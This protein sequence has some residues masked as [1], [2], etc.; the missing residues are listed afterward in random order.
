MCLVLAWIIQ[1]T[2][3][4]S[5]LIFGSNCKWSFPDVLRENSTKKYSLKLALYAEHI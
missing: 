4:V 5:L 3:L 1:K 2:L